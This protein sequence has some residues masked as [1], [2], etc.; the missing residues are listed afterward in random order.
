MSSR[1]RLQLCLRVMEK[2]PVNDVRESSLQAA[3]RFPVT[4][5]GGSLPP[6][7]CAARCFS[8][9]LGDGHGVQN[10]IQLPVSGPREPVT[11]NVT[12]GRFDGRG[13]GITGERGSRVEPVNRAN[14]AE[15]LACVQNPDP[16]QLGQ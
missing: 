4:L 8:T 7:V 15:D 12:G 5:S 6:I 16:A 9:D 13:A 1:A 2:L 11:D 3:Q 10:A 14:P